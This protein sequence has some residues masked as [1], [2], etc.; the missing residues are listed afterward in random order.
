LIRVE[1]QARRYGI[2]VEESGKEGNHAV[3]KAKFI[4]FLVCLKLF[5]GSTLQL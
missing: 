4:C 5:P 3:L 2:K 1:E